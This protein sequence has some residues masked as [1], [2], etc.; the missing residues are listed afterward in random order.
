MKAFTVSL[1]IIASLDLTGCAETK[2]T[3]KEVGHA[4]RD[5]GKEIGHATKNAA[6]ETGHFFR[7]LFK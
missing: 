5:A 7:D 3:S 1:F 4:T 2:S 6:K